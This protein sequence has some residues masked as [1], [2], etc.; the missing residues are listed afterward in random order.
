MFDNDTII[1]VPPSLYHL[2]ETPLLE[3]LDDLI[4]DEDLEMVQQMPRWIYQE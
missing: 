3:D 2:R 1:P 4:R